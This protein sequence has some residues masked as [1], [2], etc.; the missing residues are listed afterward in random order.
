MEI[1]D[2][3]MGK[4]L[5]DE[6]LEQVAGGKGKRT[7][8]WYCCDKYVCQSCGSMGQSRANHAPDCPV[9]A[10][11]C[12]SNICDSTNKVLALMKNGCWSCKHVWYG[13]NY[14]KNE[15]DMWCDK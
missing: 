5:S 9:P 12:E 3:T 7:S 4:R 14:P 2:L 8:A 6:E 13:E 15:N 10:I 11:I 1:K